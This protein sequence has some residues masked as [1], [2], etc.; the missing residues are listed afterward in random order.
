MKKYVYYITLLLNSPTGILRDT[1]MT[2]VS[3]EMTLSASRSHT[4]QYVNRIL[5]TM[6]PFSNEEAD[7]D[8]DEIEGNNIKFY[9]FNINL[10]ISRHIHKTF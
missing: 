8:I 5:S 7:V 6:E 2:Q 3:P 4:F 10:I 9:S 1:Y